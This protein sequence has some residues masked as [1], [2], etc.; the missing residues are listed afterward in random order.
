MPSPAVVLI[1]QSGTRRWWQC[2]CFFHYLALRENTG[3]KAYLSA[4]GNYQSSQPS[5]LVLQTCQIYSWTSHTFLELSLCEERERLCNICFHPVQEEGIGSCIYWIQGCDRFTFTCHVILLK[6][7]LVMSV[8]WLW[9]KSTSVHAVQHMNCGHHLSNQ[10][11]TYA[12][13]F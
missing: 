7:E 2:C 1:M 11:L 13:K 6:V 9:N 8:N 12:A 4:G 5:N 10:S 3:A